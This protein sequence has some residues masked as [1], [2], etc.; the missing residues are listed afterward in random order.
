MKLITTLVS[1][2]SGNFYLFDKSSENDELFENKQRVG[3]LIEYPAFFPNLSAY[4]NLKY[5]R[6]LMKKLSYL[7]L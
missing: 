7:L 3:S 1:P 2:T 5:Y 4:D 6:V